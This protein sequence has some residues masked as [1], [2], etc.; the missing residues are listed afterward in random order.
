MLSE[1]QEEMV[2]SSG[3]PWI[4]G[5]VE[6][7]EGN[8]SPQ[9][10]ARTAATLTSC[11]EQIPSKEQ[12]LLTCSSFPPGWNAK[13]IPFLRG[14]TAQELRKVKKG[15]GMKLRP[16]SCAFSSGCLKGCAGLRTDFQ[17]EREHEKETHAHTNNKIWSMS[18]SALEPIQSGKRNKEKRVG[19]IP[20][21]ARRGS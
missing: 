17:K 20:L 8:C 13:Q 10:S 14:G 4:V 7:E 6:S 19:A 3:F 2:S 16:Q 18:S 12:G 5:L 11:S 9:Q 1:C 15:K 21:K